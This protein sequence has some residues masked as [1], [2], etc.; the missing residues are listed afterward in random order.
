[1]AFLQIDLKAKALGRKAHLNVFLPT[2]VDNKQPGPYKTLYLLHGIFGNS[3]SWVTS[4][5]VQRYAE[6]KNLCVVM[7][8]G[9]NGF[10]I[11]HPDYMN[12]FSRYIGEELVSATREMLPLSA[13]R[14]DTLLGGFSMGGYGALYNGMKYADTFGTVIAFSSALILE[15][16]QNRTSDGPA[17]NEGYMKAMFGDLQHLV[18]SELDPLQL[19]RQRLAAGKDIPKLYLSCGEQDGLL[20][21][22]EKF[23][24]ALTEL[25]VEHTWRTTPGGHDWDFWEQ[26]IRHV[27]LEWMK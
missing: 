23:R 6:M 24:K 3:S 14:E 8:D 15:D 5:C 21:A 20:K 17:A 9:E 19:I 10:Y 4:S 13:K 11:D 22:N 18:G 1:M 2:D 7:P 16:V 25:G 12:N 27:I 26:E